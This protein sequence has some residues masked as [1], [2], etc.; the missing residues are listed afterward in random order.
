MAA[1]LETQVAFD[2]GCE[3]NPE[4]E[5]KYVDMRVLENLSAEIRVSLK[6]VAKRVKRLRQK[7]RSFFG[8]FQDLSDLST[9]ES[10]ELLQRD[11]S[12][13]IASYTEEDAPAVRHFII[14]FRQELEKVEG[15]YFSKLQEIES[16]FHAL[17]ETRRRCQN[18]VSRRLC[19]K[20]PRYLFR[21]HSY[22][23]SSRYIACV[24]F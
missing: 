16:R 17:Q 2:T 8:L 23:N 24:N 21:K 14:L 6:S 9:A 1:R 22:K 5:G 11:G 4:F 12:E 3:N 7:K 15:H 10:S 13:P 18:Q 20:S 19:I